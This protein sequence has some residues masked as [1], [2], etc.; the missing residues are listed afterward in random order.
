MNGLTSKS[1]MLS[2]APQLWLVDLGVKNADASVQ[3]KVAEMRNE[4]CGYAD[5]AHLKISGPDFDTRL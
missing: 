1:F 5:S 2:P 3:D 4:M